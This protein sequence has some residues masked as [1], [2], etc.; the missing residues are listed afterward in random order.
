MLRVQWSEVKWSEVKWSP[1]DKIVCYKPVEE[2]VIEIN[3][4]KNVCIWFDLTHIWSNCIIFR[5]NM[6]Q[7]QRMDYSFVTFK[8]LN[9]LLFCI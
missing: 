5:Q 7:W 2:S 4:E 9:K 1:D 8:K 3:Y 6:W